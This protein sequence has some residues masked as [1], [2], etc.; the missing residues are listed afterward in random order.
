[1]PV[2]AAIPNS[3]IKTGN[4]GESSVW[5]RVIRKVAA[6]SAAMFAMVDCVIPMIDSSVE[7]KT[8]LSVDSIHRICAPAFK[9]KADPY[10]N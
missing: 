2:V 7:R 1:M 4:I 6:M 9:N 5:L 3:P 8:M 10:K